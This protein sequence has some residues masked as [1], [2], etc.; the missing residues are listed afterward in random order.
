MLKCLCHWAAPFKDLKWSNVSRIKLSSLSESD[1]TFPSFQALSDLYYLFVGFMDYL[2]SCELNI[3]NS[4][5]D[6]DRKKTKLFTIKCLECAALKLHG[7]CYNKKILPV[8]RD[9]MPYS[10]LIEYPK[11]SALTAKSRC[12]MTT[13]IQMM[14]SHCHA[15]SC[16]IKSLKLPKS[17]NQLWFLIHRVPSGH[18]SN[19]LSIPRSLRHPLQH[20]PFQDGNESHNRNLRVI[21]SNGVASCS[22]LSDQGY[23]EGFYD[24]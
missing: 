24:Q 1:D 5:A 22:T 20:L 12:D 7:N 16:M 13:L 3:S 6:S 15:D 10:C 11:H 19:D 18:T 23:V 8:S 2:W 4:P 17:G 9:D 14:I 21:L